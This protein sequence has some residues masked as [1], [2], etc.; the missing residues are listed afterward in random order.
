MLSY[1]V[2]IVV[3]C[4]LI[5]LT[6]FLAKIEEF[7]NGNF[8]HRGGKGVYVYVATMIFC[9]VDVFLMMVYKDSAGIDREHFLPPCF[10]SE[11]GYENFSDDE[12]TNVTQQD[13]TPDDNDG[14]AN[15]TGD[16]GGG[17][18]DLG[19]DNS[20]RNNLVGDNPE[21]CN[22]AR[23]NLTGDNPSGRNPTEDNHA[24]NNPIGNSPLK[25]LQQD[26]YCQR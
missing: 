7:D 22:S 17:R 3:V 18:D 20:A 4:L 2:C 16:N 25:D 21:A 12:E 9:L 5:S 23:D 19:D 11:R 24:R 1:F 15:V 14:P 8:V 13:N 6:V 26:T 10:R